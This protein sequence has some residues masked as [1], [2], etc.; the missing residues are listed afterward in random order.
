MSFD[1]WVWVLQLCISGIAAAKTLDDAGIRDILIL[2]A[3]NRIGGRMMKTEF[4][5]YTVEKG[6]NWLFSGG[7]VFNPILDIA[8]KL[9][10][11]TSLSDHGNVTANTYKQEYNS[12]V[13]FLMTIIG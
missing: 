11:T 6:A 4:S 9:N 10:L 1:V 7:P 5:G 2:E 3:T 13:S 8:Q 12:F